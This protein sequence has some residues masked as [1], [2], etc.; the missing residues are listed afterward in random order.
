MDGRREIEKKENEFMDLRRKH[1]TP[2]DNTE[3]ITSLP[4][5]KS[6]QQF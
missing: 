1:L 4:I 3:G 2:G 5:I 6:M